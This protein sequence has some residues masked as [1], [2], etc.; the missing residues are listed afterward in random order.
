MRSS[1]RKYSDLSDDQKKV[2]KEF[3]ESENSGV[4][5]REFYN[6]RINDLK[7]TLREE[8]KTIDNEVI[9]IKLEEV[10]KYLVELSKTDRVG[11]DNIVDLLEYYELVK[12]IKKSHNE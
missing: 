1:T 2:L 9:K 8:I 11:N 4:K 12:E 3:I 10:S 7:F 5:L 6:S